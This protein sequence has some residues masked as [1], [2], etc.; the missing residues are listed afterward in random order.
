MALQA[1]AKCSSGW[2]AVDS[3]AF[4]LVPDPLSDLMAASVMSGLRKDRWEAISPHLDRALE[5]GPEERRAWIAALRVNDS[6]LAS[7]LDTLLKEEVAVDQEGFLQGPLPPRPV[8][9]AIAGQAMGAYTLVSV[10]GCGGMGQVWLARRSDGHFAGQAAVKILN[11]DVGEERFRREAGIL[12]RLTHPHIAHLIDAG[13]SPAGQPYLV[14]EYV[15]GERIDGYCDN[16]R[17][18]IEAR[19]RLFLDVLAA[20]AHAHTNL[21]V[22]RDIKPSNVMVNTDGRVKLLD[23]GIAKLLEAEAGD[24]GAALTLESGRALTPKYAA[25]EQLTA[26]PITTATDVYALGLVLY[27]LLT[28]RHPMDPARVSPAELL[29]AIVDTAPPRLFE[30]TTETATEVAETAARRG[31]TPER[32]HRQLSGDLD[33]IVAKALKKCAEERYPSVAALADDV[34]RYLDH[35]PISARP[36]RL[37]YRAAKFVRRNRLAVS[38]GSFVI[39]ALLGGLLGT[40]WQA[41]AAARQRDL[42]LAQLERAEGMTD[43][44]G[45]L[46]GQALPSGKPLSIHDILTRAEQLVDTRFGHDEALAVDLLVVIGNIY[47]IREE[48]DN[49]RR[50][51]KRAYDISQRVSDPAVRAKAQCGWARSLGADGDFA[52][53]HRAIGEALAATS[54]EAR[55]DAVVA[56]CL[57]NQGSIAMDE[58]NAGRAAVAGERALQ[59]LDRRP[60]AYPETRANVLQLL[61]VSRRM[62]G[63]I[64]GANRRFAEAFDQLQRIRRGETNDAGVVLANW[65]VA[66]AMTNQLEALAMNGRVMRIFQGD[67][68]DPEAVPMTIRLNYGVQLLRLARYAEARTLF[69]SA[70]ATARQQGNVQM[71]GRFSHMVARTCRGLGD[72]DC[73]R[74]GLRD[75]D[76]ALRPS[77]PPKHHVVADLVRERALLAAAEGD[78]VAAQVL[79]AE[80]IATHEAVSEKRTSHIESLLELARWELRLG[81]G[82]EAEAHAGAALALAEAL[83]GGMPQSSWVGLSQVLLGEVSLARGDAAEARRRFGEAVSQ[84]TSTLGE[85]HPALRQARARLAEGP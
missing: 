77:L 6:A 10:V 50:T 11:A 23:F 63:D 5:M 84:M 78:D 30:A 3:R 67:S 65:G 56:R 32:L 62:Q 49:V 48:S 37:G 60:G 24:G 71:A 81:R 44:T 27:V 21:I 29:K 16:R 36:D 46:L 18:G 83:R 69:E 38:L 73:V 43:F 8:T 80:A 1:L 75:A 70:G 55:F 82:S 28:G 42:A 68:G 57:V 22:H 7:A 39:L 19:L 34:R 12:A 15:D 53:A 79:F 61:G 51:M 40:F 41:R 35:Q 66:V 72:I 2:A 54:D 17:L 14:L 31:T 13:V 59:R 58:G 52:G 47:R 20:V 25:P 64:R 33:T 26:G 9:A 76:A 45:F 74:A 85:D 4:L